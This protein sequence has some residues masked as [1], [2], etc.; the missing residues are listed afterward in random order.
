MNLLVE[1]S[2]GFLCQQSWFYNKSYC[3]WL[4]YFQNNRTR[5]NLPLPLPQ[6]LLWWETDINWAPPEHKRAVLPLHQS[7]L[8]A[9]ACPENN[10]RW[11]GF[12]KFSWGQRAERTGIWG[13]KSPSQGF[14]SICKWVKP[15]FSLGCYGCIFHG[16]GNSAQ[17]C[18][19]FGIPGGGGLNTLPPPPS[20][21]H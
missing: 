14:R 5:T 20:V 6:H 19:N 11:V 7:Q 1:I 3:A 21:R 10:F 17:L 9:V 13:R 12:N 4:D 2:I 15:V 16:T 18:Q 8:I